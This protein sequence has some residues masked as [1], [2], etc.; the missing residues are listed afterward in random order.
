MLLYTTCT[1]MYVCAQKNQAFEV[2]ALLQPTRQV[3][4]PGEQCHAGNFFVPAKPV[5]S[6]PTILNGYCTGIGWLEMSVTVA[7]SPHFCL[8]MHRSITA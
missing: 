4:W 5:T 3:K 8:Y 1:C 2:V 7:H 6:T